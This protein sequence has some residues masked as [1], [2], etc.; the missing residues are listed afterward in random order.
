MTNDPLEKP[1]PSTK[2]VKAYKKGKR[3]GRKM[4]GFMMAFGGGIVGTVWGIGSGMKEVITELLPD[5]EDEEEVD[6][7]APT[8]Q[9]VPPF[10][11]QPSS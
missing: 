7:P 6:A 2:T 1:T 9:Q 8:A 11:S 10:L 5:D 3:R 4:A